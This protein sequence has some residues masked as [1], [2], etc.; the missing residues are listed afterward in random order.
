MRET[1]TRVFLGFKNYMR[2]TFLVSK[3]KLSLL[4]KENFPWKQRKTVL[5]SK[6]ID[7]LLANENVRCW[8]TKK[9][10]YRYFDKCLWTKIQDERYI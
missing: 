2:K 1:N 5:G 9:K 8:Q 3:G 4:A 6:G 10:L 7:S